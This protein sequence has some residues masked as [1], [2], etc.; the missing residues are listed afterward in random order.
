MR[1]KLANPSLKVMVSL[2]GWV[3]AARRYSEMSST[4]SSRREFIRSVSH[5][6][7]M[8]GFDGLDLFWEFPGAKDVNGKPADK[9]NF[10][11]LA[12][13]LSEVF[14]QK[15]WLLSAA[16]SPS[17]FRI[18]DGYNVPELCRYLDF[19]NVMTYDIHNERDK[20]ANHL[21]PLFKRS[22]DDGLGVFFNVVSK[23]ILTPLIQKL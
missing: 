15:G 9:Q 10:V 17:R 21:A 7:E 4:A 1:L 8:H 12:E 23:I 16:V 3:E 13:A 5:F 20:A 22:H 11:L 6:L 14:A 18:E 2:G 19:L